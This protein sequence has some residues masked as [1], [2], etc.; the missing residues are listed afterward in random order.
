MPLHVHRNG[1]APSVRD[2]LEQLVRDDGAWREDLTETLA[3]NSEHIRGERYHVVCILGDGTR[4]G[5]CGHEHRTRDAAVTC[6]YQPDAYDAD[7]RAG[8]YVEALPRRRRR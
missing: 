1:V 4:A 3:D 6:R 5:D 7:D 2:E 8:L